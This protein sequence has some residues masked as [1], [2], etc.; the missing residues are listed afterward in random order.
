MITAKLSTK[1]Q[2]V[3]PGAIRRRHHWNYGQSLVVE[4]AEDG[5][6]LRTAP[7]GKGLGK[8]VG[9]AGYCDKPKTLADMDAAIKKGALEKHGRH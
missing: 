9:I 1:G 4:D 5:V 8:L 6:L 7:A 3:I 2:I